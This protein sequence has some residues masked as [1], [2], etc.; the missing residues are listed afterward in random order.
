MA[1]KIK[2]RKLKKGNDGTIVDTYYAE[3]SVWAFE[4]HFEFETEE[5]EDK[6]KQKKSPTVIDI[7]RRMRVLLR[8]GWTQGYYAKTKRGRVVE[9]ESRSAA[10]FC[11]WGAERRAL[12][13][14]KTADLSAGQEAMNL[15]RRCARIKHSVALVDYNDTKG[16]TKKE[17]LDVVTCAIKKAEAK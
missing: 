8:K 4:V 7:L 3:S 10:T 9:A 12:H 16:R 11:L 1:L 2:L 17:I 15:V 14:L 13:E 5:S 6:M